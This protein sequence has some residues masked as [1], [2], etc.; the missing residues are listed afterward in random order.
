MP[1]IPIAVVIGAMVP[2]K[3]WPTMAPKIAPAPNVMTPI[4]DDAVPAMCG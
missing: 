4:S 3:V 1:A 2:S